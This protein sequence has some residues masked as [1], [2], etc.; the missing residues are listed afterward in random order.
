MTDT[1]DQQALEIM[2]QYSSF[3]QVSDAVLAHCAY[4]LRTAWEAEL[5]GQEPWWR[6][7][8]QYGSGPN[9]YHTCLLCGKDYPGVF[10]TLQEHVAEHLARPTPTKP[11]AERVIPAPDEIE[12]VSEARAIELLQAKIA[13]QAERIKE[14]EAERDTFHMN[15]RIKC[16]EETKR[17]EAKITQQAAITAQRDRLF[18]ALYRLLDH[19]GAGRA[20]A[21]TTYAKIEAEMAKEKTNG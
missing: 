6:N 10:N 20:F 1:K 15:Y 7:L 12:S 9:P 18:V 19:P 14:L 8:W 16:D 4:T 11:D 3:V 2:R 13:E 21:S 5:G 17:L